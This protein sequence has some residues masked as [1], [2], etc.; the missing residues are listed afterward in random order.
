MP[1]HFHTVC[2]LSGEVKT[3]FSMS[4]KDLVYA[5]HDYLAL[6]GKFANSCYKA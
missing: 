4:C 2:I 3:D 1:A 6:D 5:L